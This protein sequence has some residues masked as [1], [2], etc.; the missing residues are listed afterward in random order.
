[1]SRFLINHEDLISGEIEKLI[2]GKT[3]IDINIKG[4]SENEDKNIIALARKNKALKKGLVEITNHGFYLYKHDKS[5]SSL[6]KQEEIK[7]IWGRVKNGE[8]KLF[9]SLI[10]SLEEPILKNINQKRLIVIFSS[11]NENIYSPNLS[12]RFF[13][14]NF[15]SIQKYIPKNTYVLRIAD[16]GGVVGSFY[17]NTVFSSVIENQVQELIRFICASQ[18][19]QAERDVVLYGASKGGTAALYHAVVGGYK[20]VSIDPIVSDEYY[21]Y[22]WNDTHFTDG[23]FPVTKQEKF[24]HLLSVEKDLN[25]IFIICSE[26]SPQYKYINSIVHDSKTGKFVNF[27]NSVHPEIKDHPDVAPMTMNIATTLINGL[28]YELLK[29]N[30]NKSLI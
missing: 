6:V 20:A 29:P 16:I 24:S 12:A 27:V 13:L 8:L 4:L 21:L 23:V 10:Y 28:F 1:M 7:N 18:G 30:Y 15:E 9:K 17:L 3:L 2:Q 25:N 11:I 19:I 14:K 5:V 22:R 26:R